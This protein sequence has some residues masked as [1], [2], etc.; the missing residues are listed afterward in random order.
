MWFIWGGV[1][2][3]GGGVGN[4]GGDHK[5]RPYEVVV[6]QFD[7]PVHMIRHY[8][9]IVQN[10][11]VITVGYVQPTFIHHASRLI[12]H[13]FAIDDFAEQTQLIMATN[14]DEI[15]PF[16]RIV[17]PEQTDRTA[18]IPL[19][20]VFGFRVHIHLLWTQKYTWAGGR[21]IIC[22]YEGAGRHPKGRIIIRP[23]HTYLCPTNY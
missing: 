16:A 22:P 14:G 18:M 12:R 19:R 5:G 11:I 21:I 20:V 13:H 9:I 10:H 7:Y 17:V 4:I 6:N 2:N 15:Q 1:G 8:D 3:I 23:Y